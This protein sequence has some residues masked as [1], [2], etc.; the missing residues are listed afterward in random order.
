[1]ADIIMKH[2][3]LLL[4]IERFGIRLG[5]GDR[6]IREVCLANGVNEALALA[7]MNLFIRQPIPPDIHLDTGILSG[8]M[9]YLRNAH[10]YFLEEKLPYISELIDRFI[11]HTENP[12]TRLLQQF[13]KGYEREVDEHMRLEN[14]TVFPY[15]KAL[16]YK[17]SGQPH[18]HAALK[19]SI[20]D[21]EAHHSDIEEK[22]ED[23]THLLIKHFPPTKDRF[24]R[25]LILL[26][27]F[28]LQYDLNDHGKIEDHILTPLV[29][30]LEDRHINE[31]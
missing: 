7:V 3:R 27:L 10:R 29:K 13:F 20:A 16:L 14:S 31:K 5:F 24:Y 11:S 23:L 17:D 26:E 25:N 9:D 30:Q 4:V 18:D 12:D 15:V 19:Y 28:E 2:E 1:M 22:L 21:F 8:L 6:S